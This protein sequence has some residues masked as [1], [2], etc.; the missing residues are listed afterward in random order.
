M[1]VLS[2]FLNAPADNDSLIG[3]PY[4]GMSFFG[5][6]F[7]VFGLTMGL[8]EMLFQRYLPRKSLPVVA[9]KSVAK[10]EGE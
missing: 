5:V 7:I 3:P 4:L 6:V 8:S 9:E 10:T 1:L 2:N